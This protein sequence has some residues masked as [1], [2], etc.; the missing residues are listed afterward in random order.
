MDN[1]SL[2]TSAASILTTE[3]RHDSYLRAGALASPY[4]TPFDT[5]FSAVFAYNLA[6][7]FIVSCP[8][9]LPIILLP[10]LSITNPP[11]PANA[12]S[13]VT[14]GPGQVL[15]F[16]FDAGGFFVPVDKAAQLYVAFVDQVGPPAFVPLTRTG[17]GGERRRCRRGCRGSRLRC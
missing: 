8:L 12:S 16:A 17:E 2:L 14:A 11:P 10:K 6:Q 3:A 13:P 1:P 5:A 4:P 15:A 9:P 7:Q